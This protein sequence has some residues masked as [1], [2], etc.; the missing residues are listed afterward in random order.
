MLPDYI[1]GAEEAVDTAIHH[2]EKRG[3]PYAF[4][5]KR[6]CFTKYKMK[7]LEPDEYS[8][9]REKALNIIVDQTGPWDIIVSTTGFASRELY[10]IRDERGQDHRRDFLTVGSMGHASAIAMGIAISKPSRQV[11]C[12]GEWRTRARRERVAS[13]APFADGDGA[14]LMH[15][16]TVATIGTSKPSNFKHI[17]INNGCHDSVGGQPTKGFQ[18][19]F[20]NVAKACGYKL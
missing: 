18:V 4:L 5:V 9:S 7:K 10:E 19:D 14:L 16:G 20:L 12:I 6:Q 13:H 3:G 15:M 1:E 11:L 8:L 17:L 2:L